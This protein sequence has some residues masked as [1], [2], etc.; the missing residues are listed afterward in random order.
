MDF[1][2]EDTKTFKYKTNSKVMK[3]TKDRE[4]PNEREHINKIYNCFSSDDE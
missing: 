2:G 1:D 4:Y 3:F